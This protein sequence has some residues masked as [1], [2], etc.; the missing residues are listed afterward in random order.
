ML[1]KPQSRKFPKAHKGRIS[2]IP[3]TSQS[4]LFGSFGLIALQSSRLT[5]HQLS[6]VI[7]A[8][9][10]HFKKDGQ[11]FLRTFPHLPATQKPAEVRMGKGKGNIQ[12]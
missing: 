10:R 7:F 5:A 2:S 12:F 3:F 8:F 1:F 9:K 6:A 11:L 4:L